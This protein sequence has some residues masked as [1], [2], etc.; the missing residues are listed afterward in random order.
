MN[1]G[2]KRGAQNLPNTTCPNYSTKYASIPLTKSSHSLAV[3]TN[4]SMYANNQLLLNHKHSSATLKKKLAREE[5]IIKK[6]YSGTFGAIKGSDSLQNSSN[7]LLSET[8][9]KTRW[10]QTNTSNS[11]SA[12]I[13]SARNAAAVR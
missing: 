13:Q 10:L 11:S 12:A 5:K 3:T 1:N 9:D 6:N 4:N 2:A 7:N 8:Q